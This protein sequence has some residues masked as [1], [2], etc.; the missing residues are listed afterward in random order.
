MVMPG[1]YDIED[2]CTEWPFDQKVKSSHPIT[3]VLTYYRAVGTYKFCTTAVT[4]QPDRTLSFLVIYTPIYDS[5]QSTGW[6]LAPY[7]QGN[8]K[9]YFT[10]TSGARYDI[11]AWAGDAAQVYNYGGGSLSLATIPPSPEGVYSFIYHDD[12]FGFQTT[13]ITLTM[14]LPLPEGRLGL[15]P[16]QFNPAGLTWFREER[17]SDGRLRLVSLIDPGCALQE[18]IPEDFSEALD[19]GEQWSPN[20]GKFDYSF[21]PGRYDYQRILVRKIDGTTITPESRVAFDLIRAQ[22]YP[23]SYCDHYAIT[24]LLNAGLL[25][26]EP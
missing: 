3:G 22:D 9:V 17:A 18:I 23:Q 2:V 12:T 16:Y 26:F 8:R 1:V 13:P 4:V 11:A 15:S 25:P 20:R 5:S 7:L 24:P 6:L 21:F 19:A 14:A 10:D